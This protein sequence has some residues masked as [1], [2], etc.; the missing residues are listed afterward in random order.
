MEVQN[1]KP[2]QKETNMNWWDAFKMI[3]KFIPCIITL[4]KDL[5]AAKADDGKVGL[6][7]II[8]A[9]E[10]FIDCISSKMETVVKAL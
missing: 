6:D 7:E 3:A 2:L 5:N 10:K 9:A 1:L 4:M 8:A